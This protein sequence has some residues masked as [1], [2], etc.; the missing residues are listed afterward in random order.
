MN[1]ETLT[2]AAPPVLGRRQIAVLLLV[3]SVTFLT[4]MEMLAKVY[5]KT[6]P[7][8]QLVWAKYF[9]HLVLAP[10]L[11]LSMASLKG[12]ARPKS[13]PV[14][15][16]R[17]LMLFGATATFFFALKEIPLFVAN[18]IGFTSP[19]LTACLAVVFLKE[20]GAAF[21]IGA[22]IL[23]LVGVVIVVHP[24]AQVQF[25]P[26]MLLPLL[27]ALFYAGYTLLTRKLAA[28]ESPFAMLLWTPA[29][30]AVVASALA[31]PV[32]RMPESLDAWVPL[33][34][35]GVCSCLGH[36]MFILALA[37]AE[38]SFLA[39]FQYLQLPLAVAISYFV[40]GALPSA[41]TYVG[42]ALIVLSGLLLVWYDSRRPGQAGRR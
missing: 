32:F 15:I 26:A 23:S 14:Q 37:R 33:V 38:A 42:G 36:L 40:F 13:V 1:T 11:L 21:R 19:L 3:G 20:R 34:L 39:P 17:S 28:T 8:W 9:F 31:A 2:V 29:V 4:G 16:A 30:G 18:I 25:S 22:A 10:L 12:V 5:A 6:F 27:T 35:L 24:T 7:T 41:Y